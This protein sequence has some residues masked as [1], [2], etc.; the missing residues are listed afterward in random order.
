LP[1]E[2]RQFASQLEGA[3]ASGNGLL[4]LSRAG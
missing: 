4:D 1:F 3:S 2:R